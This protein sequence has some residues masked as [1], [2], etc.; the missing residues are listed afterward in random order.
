LIDY[1]I[2]RKLAGVVIK[3]RKGECLKNYEITLLENIDIVGSDTPIFK[4][5]A[6][7]EA[8]LD[9]F[10]TFHP[11][12]VPICEISV[13]KNNFV[14]YLRFSGKNVHAALVSKKWKKLQESF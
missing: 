12:L 13:M 10:L 6:K 2:K 9:V 7:I 3:M 11:V 4:L 1:A 8:M 14:V 5:M